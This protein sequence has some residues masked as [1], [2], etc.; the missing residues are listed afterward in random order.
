MKSWHQFVF[1]ITNCQIVRSHLLTH[2]INY[3]ISHA[4]PWQ[5]KLV[6]E[7]ARISAVIV[8]HTFSEW[9]QLIYNQPEE[10]RSTSDKRHWH[11]SI[12]QW[13]SR[14]PGKW[15]FDK[16]E[17]SKCQMPPRSRGSQNNT[18]KAKRMSGSIN[19]DCEMPVVQR[20]LLLLKRALT[21]A[22]GDGEA[23]VKRPPQ[24]QVSKRFS[25]NFT[26]SS[27]ILNLFCASSCE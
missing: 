26:L 20:T 18:T 2:C 10:K 24:L 25:K 7:H 13:G 23:G 15:E 5:W 21:V 3:K 1:S 9:A 6:N 27:I 17:I 19:R 12:E 16:P 8:K 11:W 22:S 4:C 14:C